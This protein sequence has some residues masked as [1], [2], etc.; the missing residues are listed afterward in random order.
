MNQTPYF[1]YILRC[2]DNTLYTGITTDLQRRI[3]EHNHSPKGAKYTRNRRPVALAY[4]EGCPDKS[5]AA[6]REY[7][8]KKLT[9][10]EKERLIGAE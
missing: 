2:S 5:S 3:D 8:I 1:V 7:A 10:D 9:R 4:S 6:K